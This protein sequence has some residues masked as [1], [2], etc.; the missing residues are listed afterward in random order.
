M[1]LKLDFSSQKDIVLVPYLVFE[2]VSAF[3]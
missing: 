2:K 1:E 3:V